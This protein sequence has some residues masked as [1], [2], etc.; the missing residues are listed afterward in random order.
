MAGLTA[1][2]IT[3]RLHELCDDLAGLPADQVRP[4]QVDELAHLSDTVY[5]YLHDP[6]MADG[7]QQDPDYL[8]ALVGRSH[9]ILDR[10]RP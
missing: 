10:L 8:Q 9:D 1:V 3:R 2:D 7:P 6:D 4:S 5:S